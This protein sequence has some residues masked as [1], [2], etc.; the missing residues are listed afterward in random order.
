MS[1]SGFCDPNVTDPHT[2]LLWMFQDEDG[3]GGRDACLHVPQSALHYV[4]FVSR[5]QQ[6]AESGADGTFRQQKQVEL[7]YALESQNIRTLYIH[8]VSHFSYSS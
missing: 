3:V 2:R 7:K 5:Q 1:A 4:C 8:T 6:T